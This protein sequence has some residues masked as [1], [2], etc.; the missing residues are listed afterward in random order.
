MCSYETLGRMI[1]H[2][3]EGE[4]IRQHRVLA[5]LGGRDAVRNEIADAPLDVI[6]QLAI[7]I[8]VE[9]AAP[10]D[11]SPPAHGRPPSV[12]RIWPIAIVRRSQLAVP[13][14]SCA[15]PCFVSR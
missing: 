5:G 1:I 8:V 11:A 15:S 4:R 6:A 13:L 2:P 12:R 14:S 9:G 7:E 3:G 10:P